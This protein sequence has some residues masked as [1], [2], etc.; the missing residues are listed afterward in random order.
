MIFIGFI[1]LGAFLVVSKFQL[2]WQIIPCAILL[3]LANMGYSL[4]D[5]YK[6]QA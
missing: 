6:G 3:T 2:P 1:W 4:Y 5:I